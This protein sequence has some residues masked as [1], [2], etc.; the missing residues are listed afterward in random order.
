M[1]RD[2]EIDNKRD[3][4]K[5]SESEREREWMREINRERVYQ[6]YSG[7]ARS[8]SLCAYSTI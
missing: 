1:E 8:S 6:I 4:E 2:R 3:R 5:V 7:L